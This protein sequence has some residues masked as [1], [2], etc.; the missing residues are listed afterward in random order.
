[1]SNFNYQRELILLWM[2]L[3]QPVYVK[4]NGKRGEKILHT[5]GFWLSIL[6]ILLKPIIY[7]RAVCKIVSI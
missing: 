6:Y 4:R 3:I 1:M 7:I 2:G 5:S